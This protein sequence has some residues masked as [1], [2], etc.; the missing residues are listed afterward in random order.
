MPNPSAELKSFMSA[1]FLF[2]TNFGNLITE[3]TLSV[4]ALL[5]WPRK[6]VLLKVIQPLL[7]KQVVFIHVLFLSLENTALL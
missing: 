2:V 3:K 6:L 7:L 4:G 1:L 5:L